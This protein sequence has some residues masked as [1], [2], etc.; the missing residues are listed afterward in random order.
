MESQFE[1]NTKNRVEAGVYTRL[2]MDSY[3]YYGPRFLG[4]LWY[5][6]FQID[7]KWTLTIIQQLS[8]NVSNLQR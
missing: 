8:V 6:I 2:Y 3:Q 5:R 4:Y 1:K 7:L